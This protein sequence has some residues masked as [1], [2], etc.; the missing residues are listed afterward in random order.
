LR[1][2]GLAGR[3]GSWDVISQRTAEG[4]V[5]NILVKLGFATEP[6]WRRGRW[7]SPGHSTGDGHVRSSMV[8]ERPT[9]LDAQRPGAVAEHQAVP[10]SAAVILIVDLS[11]DGIGSTS[12]KN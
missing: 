1:Y 10:S 12:T 5:E 4:H 3:P 8:A 6:R 9:P 11:N 2:D 7:L